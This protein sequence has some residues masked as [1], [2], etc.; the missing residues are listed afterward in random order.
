MT[1]HHLFYIPAIFL[2]GFIFGLLVNKGNQQ[3]GNESKTTSGTSM[4]KGKL[5]FYSFFVFTVIFVLTHIF[6]IPWSSKEISRLINNQ[7]IF[8][9][10]PLFTS[11]EVYSKISTFSYEGLETYKRFTYTID[12]VFPISFFA[13]LFIFARYVSARTELPAKRVLKY[14][15]ILW[16]AMDFIENAIVYMI[17][18][19]YPDR[20]DFVASL[21]GII[22]VVKFGLLGCS[23]IIPSIV[24]VYSRTILKQYP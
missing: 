6:E 24:Y 12:I 21:L 5:L 4:P 13:F 10:S 15:P 9:K 20:H 17:L 22:T 7:E 11:E 14:I 23:V 18:N 1:I 19:S 8:D 3:I 2:L 16:L